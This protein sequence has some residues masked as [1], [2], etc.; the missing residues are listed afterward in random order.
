MAIVST[1]SDVK[2]TNRISGSWSAS[3][4]VEGSS[5]DGEAGSP[6]IVIDKNNIPN[7][8][9]DLSGITPGFVAALADANSPTTFSRV[10]LDGSIVGGFPSIACMPNGDVWAAYIKSTTPY[11]IKHKSGDAWAT[12]GTAFTNGVTIDGGKISI[13]TLM[14][15]V[16]V[17]YSKVTSV[18]ISIVDPNK[19]FFGAEVQI[20][21]G[22]TLSGPSIKYAF[23][24]DNVKFN[25]R[26]LLVNSLGTIQYYC[27]S[28]GMKNVQISLVSIDPPR[29]GRHI[30]RTKTGVLYCVLADKSAGTGI[31]VWKSK[32]DGRTWTQPDSGNAPTAAN[33]TAPSCAIDGFGIIHVAY[34][35]NTLVTG[36]L[37]Y[38]TF[39]T[40]SDTYSGDTLAQT[41]GA[42]AST[43]P[44]AGTSIA[45]DSNNL[46]HIAYAD[47]V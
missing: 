25:K 37:R 17:L 12:W 5:K 31:Q 29:A 9:C 20:I 16:F 28:T 6:D 34:W 30:I 2:Y 42:A 21:G 36:G 27:S 23:N 39:N 8:V 18:V 13:A 7:I 40:N 35:D 32:D 46:P 47:T 45:I 22:A 15:D 3:I 19:S 11:V 44:V 26:D 1:T 24:S 33:Y 41:V 38:V 4:E 10:T 43:V 14:N